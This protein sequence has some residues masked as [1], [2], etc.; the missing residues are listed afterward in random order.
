MSDNQVKKRFDKLAMVF[1]II[2]LV[3]FVQSMLCFMVGCILE[4]PTSRGGLYSLLMVCAIA[5]LWLDIIPGSIIAVIG[6]CFGQ[7]IE[8][9][10]FAEIGKWILMGGVVI[11]ILEVFVYLLA[12][13]YYHYKYER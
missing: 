3:F 13:I 4:Q 2:P 7:V 9:N 8:E 11:V 6:L 1:L 10:I 5:L 12:P